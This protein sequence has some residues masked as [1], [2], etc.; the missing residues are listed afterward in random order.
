MPLTGDVMCKESMSELFNNASVGAFIGAFFAFLLVA[1]TDLRRRYR[2]KKL[3][4]FLVSSNLDLAHKKIESVRMNIDL[5]KEDNKVMGAPFMHFP[6]Q[7]I[8]DYQFQVLDLLNANDKQGLDT[9]IYWMEAIDTLL[10]EATLVAGKLKILIKN[11]ASTSERSLV[12]TE[13]V[14]VLEEAETNLGH[15]VTLAEFYV[16]GESHKI[17]EFKHPV[18]DK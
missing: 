11:N 7:S 2:Y 12:G 13:Y 18:G 10:D 16:K 8:K 4:K 5:I 9:L 1:A 14:D 3:L 15:L 6:T 17:L